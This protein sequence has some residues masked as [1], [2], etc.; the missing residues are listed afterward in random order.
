LI[1]HVTSN[2]FHGIAKSNTGA[3]KEC[4]QEEIFG[5]FAGLN[6]GAI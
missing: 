1:N 5:F 2:D 4:L 3:L 6:P